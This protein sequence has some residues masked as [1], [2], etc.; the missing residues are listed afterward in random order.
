MAAGRKAIR[1]A[2]AQQLRARLVTTYAQA[3]YDD[4]PS[5]FDLSPVVVVASA[6]TGRA[7]L[8][9]QGSQ[10][11]VYL[12]VFLL[13][14]SSATTDDNLDTL[15]QQVAQWMDETQAA[16]LWTAIDYDGRSDVLPVEDK[17]GNA[18]RQERIP[19]VL[20]ARP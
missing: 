12:N 7:R 3:V 16:P 10:A 9:F 11:K 14:R 13:A 2:V 8:S 19:I 17:D 20:L 18:Y 15:E 6:G 4:Q 1:E 5:T